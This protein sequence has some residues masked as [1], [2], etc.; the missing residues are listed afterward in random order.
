MPIPRPFP[1]NP[2]SAE[3]SPHLRRRGWLPPRREG[4]PGHH[5]SSRARAAREPVR[6]HPAGSGSA[7]APASASST[8]ATILRCGDIRASRPGPTPRTRRLRSSKD[9]NGRSARASTSLETSPPPTCGKATRTQ[10]G[11][12]FTSATNNGTSAADASPPET[13]GIAE[14]ER[15]ADAVPPAGPVP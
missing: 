13:N 6:G 12:E 3:P 5:Q 15:L 10:G 4:D 7:S 2:L 11:A 1:G 9:T 14:A 8:L